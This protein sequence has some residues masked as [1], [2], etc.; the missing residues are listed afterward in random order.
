MNVNLYVT[1]KALV[2]PFGGKE[3]SLEK[4]LSLCFQTK[5]ESKNFIRS[6]Y[7]KIL[8]KYIKP[9][10]TS[11]ADLGEFLEFGPFIW[12]LQYGASNSDGQLQTRLVTK[13]RNDLK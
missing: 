9:K 6:G 10:D 2:I 11:S 13:R 1:S 7:D 3:K 4:V 12:N 5:F 8:N